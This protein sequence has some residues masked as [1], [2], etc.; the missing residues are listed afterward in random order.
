NTSLPSGLKQSSHVFSCRAVVRAAPC[1]VFVEMGQRGAVAMNP[2]DLNRWQYLTRD[3]SV[4]WLKYSW[5]PA[6]ANTLAARLADGT[7]VV[8]APSV[9]PASSVL[10]DLSKDGTVS[11]LVA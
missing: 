11:A 10:E 2:K 7:W 6:T 9:D 8:V 3:G 1:L 5:G 4:R